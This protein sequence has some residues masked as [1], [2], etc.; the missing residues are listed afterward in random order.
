MLWGALT[1]ASSAMQAMDGAMGGISQNIA[2]INTTG[3]KRIQTDFKTVMSESHS[4]PTNTKNSTNKN[5]ATTG[6]DIFGVR[7]VNRYAVTQQGMMAPTNNWTDLAINGRGFFIVSQPG[8]DGKPQAALDS[9]DSRNILYTRAGS[10]TTASDGPAGSEKT[11]FKTTGG[12]Y[13]MGWMADG[14]GRIAGVETTETAPVAGGAGVTSG[15]EKTLV[16]IYTTPGQTISGVATTR[17]QPVVNIPA[18]ATTTST[19]QSFTQTG[20]VNDPSGTPLALT[21][22]WQRISG[23]NWSLSYSLPASANATLT[24][25][26]IAS[27]TLTT[28]TNG[29]IVATPSSQAVDIAFGGVS[30]GS[31]TIYMGSTVPA[32]EQALVSP[33]V[34]E[35]P[36]ALTVYDQNYQA[37]TVPVYFEK[38]GNNQWNMRIRSGSDFTVTAV[39][40]NGNGDSVPV[41]FD[42]SGKIVT[43]TELTFSVNWLTTGSTTITTPAGSNSITIDTSKMTQYVGTKPGKIDIKSLDQDGYESGIL[44]SASFNSKGEL[45]GHFN[46]GRTRTLAMVPLATFTAA[47]QLNPISGTVFERTAN[48]G[49]MSIDEIAKQGS[50]NQ[51]VSSAVEASNVDLSDEFTRMIVT[52]KAYSMNATVFKTAD[53]MTTVARDLYK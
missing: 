27:V 9:T 53:E 28:D 3:Y 50:G 21:A 15:V 23:N 6:T 17:F 52:Q 32:G 36:L 38:E 33:T 39:G 18:D 37:R 26:T 25:A 45:I 1:N 34:N 20:W 49:T 5:T 31:K 46:N 2:N 16:P 12:Q 24:P 4:A 29:K 7:A 47:D 13:L 10:F 11:Y 41:T 40:P 48:A 44:D 22:S 42:G 43:P 19:N 30:A 14:Q 35:I 51:F 8:S